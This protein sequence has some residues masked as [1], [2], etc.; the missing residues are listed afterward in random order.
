MSSTVAAEVSEAL[1]M[2]S[3]S[4]ERVEA[5]A[6]SAQ[7]RQLR[8]HRRAFALVVVS[9]LSLVVLITLKSVQSVPIIRCNISRRTS[10]HRQDLMTSRPQMLVVIR[11]VQQCNHSKS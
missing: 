9:E 2:T 10:Y 5:G 4:N 7:L 6:A 11:N 8:Y 1:W 3:D